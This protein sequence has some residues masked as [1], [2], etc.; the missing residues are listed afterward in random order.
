MFLDSQ[1]TR[2]ANAKAIGLW[3]LQILTGAA[4]LMAGYA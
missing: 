2:R 1:S 3:T 4:F